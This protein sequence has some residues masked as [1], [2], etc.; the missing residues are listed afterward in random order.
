MLGVAVA[1][2]MAVVA[3]S[4]LAKGYR[5]HTHWASCRV[6]W[7]G[8]EIPKGKVFCSG[9]ERSFLAG[10]LTIKGEPSDGTGSLESIERGKT[11]A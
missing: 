1:I 2:V 4:M 10:R 11:D 5:G 9:H 3:V 7:C 8:V 6:G